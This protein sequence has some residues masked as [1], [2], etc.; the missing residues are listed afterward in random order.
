MMTSTISATQAQVLAW[1]KTLNQGATVHDA[2]LSKDGTVTLF[3]KDGEAEGALARLARFFGAGT[4]LASSVSL[5]LDPKAADLL[6][7]TIHMGEDGL[8]VK[9]M[10]TW[11]ESAAK[12]KMKEVDSSAEKPAF[13]ATTRNDLTELCDAVHDTAFVF[14]RQDAEPGD[15]Q[16]LFS[17]YVSL[18]KS[19]APEGAPKF[20]TDAMLGAHH[21]KLFELH[22]KVCMADRDSWPLVRSEI[23]AYTR[24]LTNELNVALK[25]ESPLS[26]AP[27]YIPLSREADRQQ[28]LLSALR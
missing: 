14:L 27:Q 6:V 28:R 18:S 20:M 8:K 2:K 9:D 17:K 1:A 7:N 21:K 24:H 26:A 5:R 12:A 13:D 23:A 19:P 11:L 3:A 15:W 25:E 4:S 10:V 22:G 16:S